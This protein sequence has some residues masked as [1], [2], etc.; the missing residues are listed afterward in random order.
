VPQLGVVSRVQRAGVLRRDE[1]G[2]VVHFPLCQA[3]LCTGPFAEDRSRKGFGFGV[4]DELSSFSCGGTARR[5]CAASICLF[6]FDRSSKAFP[7]APGSVPLESVEWRAAERRRRHC[8]APC[9][10]M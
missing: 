10:E 3:G 4:S 1:G 8:T 6:F 7:G 9:M 2:V 5:A